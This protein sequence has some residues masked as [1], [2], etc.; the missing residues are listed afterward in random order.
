M[1]LRL[2]F[3]FFSCLLTAPFLPLS[4]QVI[5]SV[6]GTN[7]TF[8]Q[9]E[10]AGTAA[11]FV[12]VVGIVKDTSGNT[13]V[14]D[15]VL[16]M[17]FKI[18]TDRRVTIFAGNGIAGYSGDGG[19][20]NLAS[21]NFPTGMAF[22]GSGNLYI[23]DVGNHRIR[24]VATN[25]TITTFAGT[26]TAG[27]G[28]D[29]VLAVM[30]PANGPAG[31]AVAPNGIV[32]YTDTNNHRIRSV[33]TAGVVRTIAG[34]AT[35][36]TLG[37]GGPA[38]QAMMRFPFGL[39]RDSSGNLVYADANLNRIR[40]ITPDG[41]ISTIAGSGFFGYNGDNVAATAAGLRFPFH[42]AVD[43]GG[44]T[45]IADHFNRRV[46][47]VRANGTIITVAGTG[48]AGYNGDGR[49]AS[50]A[51]IS[52]PGGVAA[53]AA[54]DFTFTDGY[55]GRI[56]R[57]A[58]SVIQT[59]A[60]QGVP[61]LAGNTN[62]QFIPFQAPNGLQ[63]DANG[64]LYVV[65]GKNSR[66]LRIAPGGGTTVVAGTGVAGFSG[67]NGPATSATLFFPE[68]I[69]LDRSG[70][71]FI[72]DFENDRI[73]R[74][75]ANGTI[76]TVAGTG[77]QG[78]GGEGIATQLPVNHP[79]GMTTDAAGNLYFADF[80]NGRVRKLG[81]DGRTELI[82]GAGGACTP[83]PGACNSDGIQA[84]NAVLVEPSGIVTDGQG[85]FW[86]A[87]ASAHRVRR[88]TI[89][90]T[91]TTVAGTG[92]A[93]YSGDGGPG[94]A[95]QLRGPRDL[96]RDSAG[97]LYI[98]ENQNHVVRVL[99]PG[100]T[101][102]TLAGTGNAGFSGDGGSPQA[103][104]LN[105]P[106]GIAIAA[107]GDVYISDNN[108][109]RAITASA[110]AVSTATP[111]RLTFQGASDSGITPPQTVR[112]Q[113]NMTG[114]PY[115]VSVPAASSWVKVNSQSGGL[116]LQLEVTADTSGL[117]PGNYSANILVA[118]PEGA[119]IAQ[120]L[121]VTLN[122]GE[123]VP[124]KLTVDRNVVN[125]T[126]QRG[127]P[128]A[129][130]AVGLKVTGSGA[131]DVA[132]ILEQPEKAG[133]LKATLPEPRVTAGKNGAVHLMID[134]AGL[135]TNTYT[136]VVNVS[137][138]AASRPTADETKVRVNLVVTD[139]KQ[140]FLLPLTVLS[141]Q[142]SEGGE[143]PATQE[144]PLLN[145]GA[146]PLQWAGT[147][148]TI[149][150]GNWL[151]LGT[152]SGS[153][154]RPNLD[155]AKIPVIVDTRSLRPGNYFG[156]LQ[157]TAGGS[158]GSPQSVSVQLNVV[159]R[160][161]PLPPQIQPSA[162]VFVGMRGES[163]GGQLTSVINSGGQPVEFTSVA[164]TEQGAWLQYVPTN[165]V[166]PAGRATPV[167]VQS[168]FKGL[169]PG[170]HTGT[171]QF[172]FADGSV[173]PLT[174]TSIV[175]DGTTGSLSS[176]KTDSTR[177]AEG[178]FAAPLRLSLV[179][180]QPS[181]SAAVN[182]AVPFTL[183]VDDSCGR[184]VVKGTNGVYGLSALVGRFS[185]GDGGMAMDPLPGGQFSKSVVFQ[186]A[187]GQT[188]GELQA[189]ALLPNNELIGGSLRVTVNLG[190]GSIIPPRVATSVNSASFQENTPVAP[191]GFVT[192][193]G[194]RLT[195]GAQQ[196]ASGATLPTELGNTRVLLGEKALP[197]QYVSTGQINA[198]IP[199]E[200]ETNAELPLRIQRDDMTSIPV[201]FVVA[202]AQPAIFTSAQ[203]GQGQA[204]AVNQSGTVNGVNARAPRGSFISLYCTGLGAV[205]PQ[206]P[207]GQ[208]APTTV[209]SHT[210]SP[211]TATVGGIQA[212]VQFAGLAPGYTGL[213]QVNV[214]IPD[215]VPGGSETEV[216]LETNGQTSPPV[217]IAI[218]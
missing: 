71:L 192:L 72:A 171:I 80:G 202:K 158:T 49:D 131:M 79:R 62:A 206:V 84:T 2:F 137:G 145:T 172:R 183:R 88:F 182:E 121:P 150:G 156:T 30:S 53:D 81:T 44:N 142:G 118:T 186:Q 41:I 47:A 23:A 102:R 218:Q 73:R 33:D 26:G 151:R 164:R 29:N 170:I 98:T 92:V 155:F 60:G 55:N 128:A 212:E 38:L 157:F 133:W 116:P 160:G 174:V 213:Y 16:H 78:Y 83:G 28:A 45:F 149:S 22:D 163:P 74:V 208:M 70:N 12:L 178:C 6:A 90:G 184:P 161:T 106:G 176:L 181:F 122:V 63:F 58:D 43:A 52:F 201:S 39:H 190:S 125:I 173:R 193:F 3:S 146:G 89:G 31:V 205:N 166:T 162:L 148:Q 180:R 100:G 19:P 86:I 111:A 104:T 147:A 114:L 46:R 27:N 209:L 175:S 194:E 120:V 50:T 154:Q 67:D 103:A 198:Q 20:A 115:T 110:P 9:G 35:A 144:L 61:P 135:A 123:P 97:N 56:R 132:A 204:A 10:V 191:G 188:T 169:E 216:I 4:A 64:N 167:M 196:G 17:V 11:P 40:R 42:A 57:V 152:T 119:P 36:T 139:P 66:V 82:A 130:Q 21:L 124:P 168:D 95:A 85:T 15:H 75:A 69:A 112:V 48:Q 113:S 105:Q 25:G 109:I 37:D 68:N 13:Y 1:K 77:V 143:V 14:T 34:S 24:R 54:L 117:S 185:N 8:P 165:A 214:R 215:G 127:E 195:G 126:L 210:V 101:I 87:E 94:I 153:V 140:K 159:A 134:P 108:R 141:F 5:S 51:T 93:G 96:A 107:N 59:I 129:F 18:T 138:S 200:V 207:A 32:Y 211:V 189:I 187:A 199:C 136:T 177:G 91:I 217:T 179:N 76:T 197:L 7:S 99:S 203:N 65:D